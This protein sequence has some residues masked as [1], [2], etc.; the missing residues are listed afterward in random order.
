M[1]QVRRTGDAKLLAQLGAAVGAV[2][3]TGEEAQHHPH[4]HDMLAD[5]RHLALC[6][7]KAKSKSH[8]ISPLPRIAAAMHRLRNTFLAL[9]AILSTS[10]RAMHPPWQR[11][12]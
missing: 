7:S 1:Q 2:G 3:H 9:A 10:G 12:E 4:R 11:R 8:V 6:A 5:D